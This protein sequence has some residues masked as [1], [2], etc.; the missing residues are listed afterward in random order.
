MKV[1]GQLLGFGHPSHG[2][3]SAET[4]ARDQWESPALMQT[5]LTGGSRGNCPGLTGRTKELILREAQARGQKHRLGDRSAVGHPSQCCVVPSILMCAEE[6]R[7]GR[8]HG[9][10]SFLRK[11]VTGL[12]ATPRFLEA[13]EG[14]AASPPDPPHVLCPDT[15]PAPPTSSRTVTN[16]T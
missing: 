2:N 10:M 1:K 15:C 8:G 5:F 14:Q 11:Q 16:A 3:L 13:G 7:R 4:P 9:F 6:N 12:P